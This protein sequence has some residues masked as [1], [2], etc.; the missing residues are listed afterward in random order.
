MSMS[1]DT[2]IDRSYERLTKQEIDRRISDLA[3]EIA[4][5]AVRPGEPD[6][7]DSDELRPRWITAAELVRRMRSF[8]VYN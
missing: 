3:A 1:G 4:E 6:S 8:I 5:G 2:Q 7:H